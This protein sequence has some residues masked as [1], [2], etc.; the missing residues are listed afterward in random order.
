MGMTIAEKTFARTSG[1]ETV[2]PGQYVDANVERIIADEEFHRIH[3]S[4]VNGGF[5]EG[6]PRIWDLE[7]VHVVLEHFQPALNE[8][9]AIRQQLIRKAIDKYGIRYFQD[10]VCA[11]VHQA[12]AEDYALPGELSLGTDS[13]STAWGALNCVSTGM[14]E[15][16]LAYAMCFGKLWF[17]VPQSIKII[18]N[19]KLKPYA[20]PKDL[21]LYLAKK[22]SAS[23]GLYKSLEFTGPGAHEMSIA[24]RLTVSAHAVELGAKFGIFEYDEKTRM[25]LSRR[26]NLQDKVAQASPVFA[27]PD[28]VYE[29]VIT[30]NL[31]EI[32]PMVAKPHSFE[33]VCELRE[34]IGIPIHQAQVGSCANGRLED[35]RAVAEIIKGKRVHK[36]T[37]FLVQPASWQ[38]YKDAMAEGLFEIMIDAGIQVLSPG[39]HLC[40]GMQGRLGENE[41]AITCT[42]RNHKGRLGGVNCSVYLANPKVITAAAIAGEIVDVREVYEK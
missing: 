9:Q 14:G 29:Q 39:C 38:V 17:K 32:E 16:E 25:F 36:N 19:G 7:R 26:S 15:H 4:A 10:S 35:L 3:A 42:T 21:V 20:D 41:N 28:A 12:A 27:D 33:N 8:T 30:I 24:N 1:L 11:V 37:R 6:I 40:L 34:V 23:F 5:P 22:Y 31:D 13:H 18:L 2:H